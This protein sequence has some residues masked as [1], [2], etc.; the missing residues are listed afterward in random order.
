MLLKLDHLGEET[1]QIN[2]PGILELGLVLFAH[3]LNP[4]KIPIPVNSYLHVYEW[5][6]YSNQ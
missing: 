4:V 2:A 3:V 5:G 1:L 6:W